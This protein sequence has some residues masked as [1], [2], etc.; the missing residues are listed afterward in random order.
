MVWKYYWIIITQ[1]IFARRLS[2][3]PGRMYVT[4]F[5]SSMLLYG[6]E[7]GGGTGYD[8]VGGDIAKKQPPLY[9][10]RSGGAKLA[11]IRVAF[12]SGRSSYRVRFPLP[13]SLL[14]WLTR[15]PLPLPKSGSSILPSA[16]GRPVRRRRISARSDANKRVGGGKKKISF[17]NYAA[18]VH[19]RT[20]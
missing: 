16:P 7:T 9:Q 14:R 15:L 19:S 13:S 2:S 6:R 5:L 8:R 17:I 20:G 1:L 18:A 4:V 3:C 11:G 10:V 12:L